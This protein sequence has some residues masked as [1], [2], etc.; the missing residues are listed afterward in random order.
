MYL[1]VRHYN[2]RDK[3][4]NLPPPRPAPRRETLLC[5]ILK[6][7][8]RSPKGVIPASNALLSESAFCCAQMFANVAPCSCRLC[9]RCVNHGKAGFQREALTFNFNNNMFELSLLNHQIP[10]GGKKTDERILTL[11]E[12]L[13]EESNGLDRLRSSG[14]P[15]RTSNNNNS[16]FRVFPRVP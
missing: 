8:S 9:S 4:S 2:T 5:K 16:R 1:S 14:G 7:S 12:P 11:R 15:S 10:E 3:V 13:A 6:F